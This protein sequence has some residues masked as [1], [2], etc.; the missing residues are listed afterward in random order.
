MLSKYV[1]VTYD[2]LKRTGLVDSNVT[3]FSSYK[4]SAIYLEWHMV[5]FI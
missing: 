4:H 3:D 5:C 2:L 1:V